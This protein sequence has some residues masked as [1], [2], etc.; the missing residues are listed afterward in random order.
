MGMGR[1]DALSERERVMVALDCDVDEA[2]ALALRLKGHAVWLKIGITLVYAGGLPLVSELHSQG[3]HVFVDAK[4]HDIP[5]QVQGAVLSAA[6]SGADLVSVHSLGGPAMLAACREGAEAARSELGRA[7]YLAAI[8]VLTSFDAT[9]LAQIGVSRP[10][11]EEV[12]SLARLSR[13][14][15]L[16]GVVCSPHEAS[17]MRDLL[18]SD[19]LVITPGVRPTS[20][21]VSDQ[22]RVA[23]PAAAIAAGASHIVVGRPVTQ[24]SDPVRAFDSIVAEL[25]APTH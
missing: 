16:D 9:E 3:F 7:P 12:C 6:R 11:P 20:S 24:A 14:A 19:A 8:T 15:G 21:A 5:H 4:F 17:Q 10:L 25:C 22:R 13:H 18:G 23:T 1:F 2:R